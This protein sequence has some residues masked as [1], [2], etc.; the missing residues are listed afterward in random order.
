M[1]WSEC[2]GQFH[3][4]K[5]T[6]WKRVYG[7][8]TGEEATKAICINVFFLKKRK[9]RIRFYPKRQACRSRWTGPILTCYCRS[10]INLSKNNTFRQRFAD[11]SGLKQLFC[12]AFPFREC[13]LSKKEGK[14][15]GLARLIPADGWC[16]MVIKLGC[17]E[18]TSIR[19][20]I[21]NKKCTSPWAR[22]PLNG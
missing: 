9:K 16:S 14:N 21:I 3:K 15:G 11:G 7:L 22:F 10:F 20:H 5:Y 2:K 13:H 17:V 19:I 1:Q 4:K 8:A 6:Y 18:A 12:F